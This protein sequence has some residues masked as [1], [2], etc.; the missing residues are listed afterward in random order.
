MYFRCTSFPQEPDQR[1]GRVASYNRIVDEYHPLPCQVRREGVMLQVDANFAQVIIRL[2]E[3][4][5]DE[6]VLS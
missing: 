5:A 4:T 6:P 3:G 1:T 2:D